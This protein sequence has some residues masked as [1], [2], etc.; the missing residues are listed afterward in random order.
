ML[1]GVGGR[2]IAEAKEN[3]SHRE[4]IAWSQYRNKH[5]SLHLGQ[6]IELSIALLAVA[7]FKSQG[8]KAELKDFMPNAEKPVEKFADIGE[9]FGLFKKLKKVPA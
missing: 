2:T 6:R 1:N 4:A 3:I 9:V 7:L 8:L 5:G